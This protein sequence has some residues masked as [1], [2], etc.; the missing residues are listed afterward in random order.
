MIGDRLD[1]DIRFGNIFGMGT[2]FVLTGIHT[3]Q[4]LKEFSDRPSYIIR[5]ISGLNSAPSRPS[6]PIHQQ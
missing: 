2:L 5:S 1:T 3:L 4:D 6:S